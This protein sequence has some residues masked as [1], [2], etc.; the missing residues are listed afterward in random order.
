MRISTEY[1]YCDTWGPINSL[2]K[3]TSSK[4]DLFTLTSVF[5]VFKPCRK[6][7]PLGEISSFQ[8]MHSWPSADG[9]FLPIFLES[10]RLL[11]PSWILQPDYISTLGI[12]SQKCLPIFIAYDDVVTAS[13]STVSG[14]DGDRRV[15]FLNTVR[16]PALKK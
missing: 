10:F 4:M 11:V 7:I 14:S 16:F 15:K 6:H 8:S 5:A 13:P 1:L 12:S 2:G 9:S 3:A